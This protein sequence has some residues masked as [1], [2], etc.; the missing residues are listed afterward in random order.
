MPDASEETYATI[1]NVIGEGS[2]GFGVV[3]RDS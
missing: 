3:G 1:V 2:D